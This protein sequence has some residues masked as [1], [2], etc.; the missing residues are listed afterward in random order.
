MKRANPDREES[1]TAEN[2]A[3]IIR[4]AE[5][6]GVVYPQTWDEEARAGLIVSLTEIN[7]RGLTTLMLEELPEYEGFQWATESFDSNPPT[8]EEKALEILKRTETTKLSQR[9]FNL[10]IRVYLNNTNL[11]EKDFTEFQELYRLVRAN[12]YLIRLRENMEISI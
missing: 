5:W 12:L 9:D 6:E 3:D 10:V 8:N 7:Y 1:F 4:I 2:Q 11:E